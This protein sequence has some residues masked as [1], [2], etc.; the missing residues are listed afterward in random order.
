M[1]ITPICNRCPVSTHVSRHFLHI[2]I[3]SPFKLFSVHKYKCYWP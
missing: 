3:S 1:K 2:I